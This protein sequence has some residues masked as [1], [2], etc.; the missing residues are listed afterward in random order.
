MI[1]RVY[2]TVINGIQVYT[3]IYYSGRKVT[4]LRTEAPETVRKFLNRYN[5]LHRTLRVP[6]LENGDLS[7]RY[8]SVVENIG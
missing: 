1:N 4:M 8:Y 7:Y 3:V 2:I 5:N 6:H